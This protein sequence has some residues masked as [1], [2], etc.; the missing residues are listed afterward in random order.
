[1]TL[2]KISKKY[3]LGTLT[4]TLVSVF[5]ATGFVFAAVTISTNIQVGDGVGD[6]VGISQTLNGDD[7]YIEGTFEVDGAARLDGTVTIQSNDSGL[8]SSGRDITL[9][10]N[11]ASTTAFDP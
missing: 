10:I 5:F 6:G 7:L 3:I 1:M 8:N 4:A 2:K 9:I 11:N